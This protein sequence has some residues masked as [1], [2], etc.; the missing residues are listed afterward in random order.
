MI[1]AAQRLADQG[2]A[3]LTIPGDVP[4]VTPTDF[5]EIISAHRSSPSFVIVLA[6]DE[7]GRSAAEIY[8]VST[9]PRAAAFRRQ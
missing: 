3:M 2:A 8:G 7:L 5:R 1:A 9:E 4:L 6:R